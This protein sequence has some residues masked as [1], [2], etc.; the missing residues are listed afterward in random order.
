MRN[1]FEVDQ[2]DYSIPTLDDLLKRYKIFN[3]HLE[4]KS[5]DQDLS[6]IVLESLESNGWLGSKKEF[7]ILGE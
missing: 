3:L 5:R 2:G 4:L 7:T 6:E 1:N